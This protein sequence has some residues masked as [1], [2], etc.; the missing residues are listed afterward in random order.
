MIY[1]VA[2]HILQLPLKRFGLLGAVG[3]DV[4]TIMQVV[5][6]NHLFIETELVTVWYVLVKAE[7]N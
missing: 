5:E 6:K 4:M 2:Y 7:K 1:K 3:P